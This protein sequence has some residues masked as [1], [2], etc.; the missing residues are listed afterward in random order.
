MNYQINL[1]KSGNTQISEIISDDVII[2]TPQDA[3][4]LMANVSTNHIVLYEHN[5]DEEFFDLST[6]I[7][8]EILQKF[9][10]YFVKLAIIGDFEKYPS[11]SLKAFI[12]ESNINKS[13]LFLP[14]LEEVKKTW[15][16]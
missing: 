12:Y 5:F 15:L 2:K 1:I 10:N 7:A 14:T 11:E 4:D 6:K 8:G 9:T 16:S 13:Y 3:L